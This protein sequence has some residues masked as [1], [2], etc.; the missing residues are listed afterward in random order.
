L[1]S[2]LR[3]S[4]AERPV[5]LREV[6]Q[7]IGEAHDVHFMTAPGRGVVD[8]PAGNSLRKGEWARLHT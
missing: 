1:W 8:G 7:F 3:R 4:P 5:V 2:L 6:V